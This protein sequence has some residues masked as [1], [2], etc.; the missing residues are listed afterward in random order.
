[1]LIEESQL[2]GRAVF[3]L[4]PGGVVTYAEIVSDISHEPDYD[5][6]LRTLDELVSAASA[7][8]A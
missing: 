2:L 3:V 1:M 7:G 4:D 6:A 5:A 8:T